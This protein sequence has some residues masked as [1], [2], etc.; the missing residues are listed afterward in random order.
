MSNTIREEQVTRYLRIRYLSDMLLTARKHKEFLRRSQINE[1]S[2]KAYDEMVRAMATAR[3]IQKQRKKTKR[4]RVAEINNSS[5]IHQVSRI[6][7]NRTLI[8][9]TGSFVSGSRTSKDRHVTYEINVR[10]MWEYKVYNEIYAHN[11]AYLG[12]WL[13]LQAEKV[14]VNSPHADLF[15]VSAFNMDTGI[16]RKG[17]VARTKMTPHRCVIEW[18]A[19]NAVGAAEAVVS[20]QLDLLLKGTSN[21]KDR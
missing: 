18:T 20:D 16:T 11:Y 13:I 17:Y 8:V 2:R 15:E 7:R 19:A 3:Q 6:T 4:K 5:L 12:P 1:P 10:Y 21:D 14:R 9:K